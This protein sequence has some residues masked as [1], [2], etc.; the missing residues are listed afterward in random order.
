MEMNSLPIEQLTRVKEKYPTIPLVI[1]KIKYNSH[2]G[3]ICV[4]LKILNAPV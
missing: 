2:K 1:N 4:D 3:I